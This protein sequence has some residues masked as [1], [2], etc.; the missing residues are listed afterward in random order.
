MNLVREVV[1][2]DRDL[3]NMSS[4]TGNGKVEERDVVDRAQSLWA[5]LRERMQALALARSE[6]NADQIPQDRSF[7]LTRTLER[8]PWQSQAQPTRT[9]RSDLTWGLILLGA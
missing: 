9:P 3:C 2:V 1:G 5:Y 6:H 8:S 4:H 7:A